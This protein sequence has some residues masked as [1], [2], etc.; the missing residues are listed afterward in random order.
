MHSGDVHKALAISLVF[1][2]FDLLRDVM[3]RSTGPAAFVCFVFVIVPLIESAADILGPREA[4]V[5]C[6][7]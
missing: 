3:L 5:A 1:R 7:T 4:S 2:H 6:E